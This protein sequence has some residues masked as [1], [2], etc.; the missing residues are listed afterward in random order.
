MAKPQRCGGCNQALTGQVL[1]CDGRLY[2]PPCFKCD[3]C[4]MSITST[5]RVFGKRKLCLRCHERE[6][7]KKVCRRCQKPLV[8]QCVQLGGDPYHIDCLKCGKCKRRMTGQEKNA[9]GL[10]VCAY[11]LP[12]CCAC[13]ETLTGKVIKL[14]SESYHEE[15]FRCK[16]C[17][18]PIHGKYTVQS[19]GSPMCPACFSTW[20]EKQQRREEAAI[21]K[22]ETMINAK[23]K[24]RYGLEW[25]KSLSPSSVECLKA[26]GA[27]TSSLSRG[28]GLVCL[29]FETVGGQARVRCAATTS[30]E[31]SINMS[32][33]IC[34][35]RVLRE[36]KRE[37][38]FSLDP[39]DPS[40]ISGDKQ[41]K[42]FYPSWLE[43]TV[44]G[45]VLFLADYAL[46]EISFGYL[47]LPQIPEL[48]SAWDQACESEEQHAPRA[49][50]QWFVVREAQIGVSSDGVIM[51]Q[52]SLGVEAR[53][54]VLGPKG[55]ED[56]ASTDP[57]DPSAVMAKAVTAAFPRLAQLVPAVAEL[58]EVAKAQLVA[59]FLLEQKAGI[60][61]SALTA[62]R[63]PMVKTSG[64]QKTI[65]SL[66]KVRAA[67]AMDENDDGGLRVTKTTRTMHGGVDLAYKGSRVPTSKLRQS[68]LGGAAGALIDLPL[69]TFA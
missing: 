53:Q 27:P 14:D 8:G 61:D 59:R 37:A 19:D 47:R 36:Y 69:F 46:K 39:A 52:F 42:V 62:Y 41:R 4:T 55:Y 54:L 33:L 66:K 20:V 35:L 18:Q 29:H 56:A 57:R 45:E 22:K 26:L 40:N 65:P 50:R 34:A 64:Y 16:S 21:V 38:Q 49:S 28:S 15:C 25:D 31:A 17:K 13:Q 60:A 48:I 6:C 12:R 58:M 5:Y 30:P 23:N 32:Y 63:L 67:R 44:L 2:H 3:S 7:Q 51:P 43:N 68:L 24:A 10:V 9:D 11:C 1:E